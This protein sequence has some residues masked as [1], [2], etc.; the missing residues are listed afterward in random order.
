MTD[1]TLTPEQVLGTDDRSE[2]GLAFELTLA[3]ALPSFDQAHEIL[4]RAIRSH[5]ALRWQ[6]QE[7]RDVGT[8]LVEDKEEIIAD[9]REQLRKADAVA[10]KAALDGYENGLEFAESTIHRLIAAMR[11]VANVSQSLGDSRFV[12]REALAEMEVSDD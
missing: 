2:V 10:D 4:Q 9:L 12:A 7:C 6:L 3:L 1:D 11:E 5:E 8:S